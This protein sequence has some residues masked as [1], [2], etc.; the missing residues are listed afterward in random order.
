MVNDAHSMD[1][2][3]ERVIFVQKASSKLL[4]TKYEGFSQDPPSGTH[5]MRRSSHVLAFCSLLNGQMRHQWSSKL[6]SKRQSVAKNTSL[7][8]FIFK[9]QKS[10]KIK[11]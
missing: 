2:Y 1:L 3:V 9:V 4:G 8:F 10:K 5:R 11:I 6:T 7:Q